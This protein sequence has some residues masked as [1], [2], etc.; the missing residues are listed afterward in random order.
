MNRRE[1][2][3]L[4]LTA[5]VLYV[6]TAAGILLAMT[7]MIAGWSQLNFLWTVPAACVGIAGAWALMVGGRL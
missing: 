2:F 1:V 7:P 6:A 5:V 3:F 4:I